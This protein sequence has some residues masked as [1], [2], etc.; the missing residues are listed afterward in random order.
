MTISRNSVYL[1]QTVHEKISELEHENIE[2]TNS[3]YELYN[4]L[5]HLEIRIKQLEDYI[6]GDNK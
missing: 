6:I 5:D 1:P 3:I 4:T 2:T